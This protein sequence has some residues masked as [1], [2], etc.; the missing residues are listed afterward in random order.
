MG[1]F[2]KWGSEMRITEGQSLYAIRHYFKNA[3]PVPEIYGWC[4]DGDEVFLYMEAISGRTLE[5]TW[6]EMEVN[7][8]LRIRRELR[9][10]SIL[11]ASLSKTPPTCLL[12][13]EP[14]SPYL[15]T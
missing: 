9:T 7:D 12:V 4:T 3:V 13:S 6:S 15:S 5:Q 1:L 2:V 8:C 14:A 10:I 11:Y